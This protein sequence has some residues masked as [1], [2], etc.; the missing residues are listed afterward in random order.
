MSLYDNNGFSNDIRE[1]PTLRLLQY[2]NSHQEKAL[3]LSL[4]TNILDSR[5]IDFNVKQ[6][7][8]VQ[9]LIQH[10]Q[11]SCGSLL[12]LVMES[13]DVYQNPPATEAADL[14]GVCHGI[15]N[16]LRSSI[17]IAS[18]TGKIIIPADLCIKYG[19]RSPRFLLSALGQGDEKCKE[20]L[21]YA[22][23]DLSTVAREH[24]TRARCLREDLILP[25]RRTRCHGSFI[26]RCC[27]GNISQSP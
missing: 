16:A 23:R 15:T 20:A 26:A 7:S 14:M 25:K 24:L 22:V 1:H 27:L 9:D 18:Q 4:L 17:P 5:D 10:S 21:D 13:A 19:V 3:S 12:K 8:T 11:Q 6:Y 2:Y